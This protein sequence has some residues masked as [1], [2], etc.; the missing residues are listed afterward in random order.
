[1]TTAEPHHLLTPSQTSVPGWRTDMRRMGLQVD[2]D[3]AW[4]TVTSQVL[5][6]LFGRPAYHEFALTLSSASLFR[7]H[8]LLSG[9]ADVLHVP[10]HG[11][12]VTYEQETRL[13]TRLIATAQYLPARRIVVEVTTWLTSGDGA[14]AWLDTYLLDDLTGLDLD[15]FD[16]VQAMW[17]A[18]IRPRHDAAR[19]IAAG[20]APH[21]A[22][23]LHDN[24]ARADRD[25]A[26][27]L[28]MA[29]RTG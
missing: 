18:G 29:L 27:D 7:L 4:V 26:I 5:P 21:E 25:A 11:H 16:A 23:T 20:F 6:S 8:H 2:A 12:V 1:M 10:V 9:G 22:R 14:E 28:L 19:Y 17:N 13:T 15:H 24:V 3:G